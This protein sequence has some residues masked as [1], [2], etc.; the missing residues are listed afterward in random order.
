MKT[1]CIYHSKVLKIG[2]IETLAFNLCNL[3]SNY[4]DITFMFSE[5]ESMD[6]ILDLPCR[7]I[8]F[9]KDK[10]YNF[11]ILILQS[12]WGDIP[13]EN[14][15]ANMVVQLIHADYT[16]LSEYHKNLCVSN[17]KHK[18]IT[19]HVA[20]SNHVKNTFE[21]VSGIK[22]DKVIYNLVC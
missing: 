8:K 1:V 15:D 9:N 7:V 19:H 3:L 14:I 21:K 17:A 20:V 16:K 12:A 22:A 18:K 2:G 5:A 11:D 4:C 6:R 13:L 10:K